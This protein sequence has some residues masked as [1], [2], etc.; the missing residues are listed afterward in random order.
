MQEIV[1]LSGLL[2]QYSQGDLPKKD[3]EGHIFTFIL[4]NRRRFHLF[5]WDKDTCVDFLCW[6]YPRMSRAI[7][8]YKDTGASFEAYIA[9]L[10]YWSAREYRSRQADHDLTE[11]AFWEARAEDMNPSENEPAYLEPFSAIK[12]VSNP[13]QILILLLKTY[14]FVSEDHISRIAP[15][16]GI[17]KAQLQKLIDELRNRRLERDEARRGLLERVECQ[18]YRCIVFRKKLETALEGSVHYEK[19]KGQ[20]E[21]AQIRYNGMRKRLAAMNHYATNREVAEVLGIP[22]GTVDSSLYAIKQKYKLVN[23]EYAKPARINA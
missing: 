21:R 1:S 8:S 2:Q 4:E 10:V 14:C 9:S 16:I 19:I 20:M 3:F 5:A 12:P 13:R 6:F 23:R 22:K 7:T 15:A 11:H 18:Y 17:E